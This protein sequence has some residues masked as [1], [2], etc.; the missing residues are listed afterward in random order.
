MSRETLRKW[1]IEAKLWRA[2]REA[3]SSS[4]QGTC[5]HRFVALTFTRLQ[6]ARVRNSNSSKLRSGCQKY[7]MPPRR[8]FGGSCI[9]GNRVHS[10]QFGFY[11]G[12]IQKDR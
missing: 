3:V 7:V 4:H 12:S 2:R 6:R 10:W 11:V 1:L 9:I 5:N 8:F